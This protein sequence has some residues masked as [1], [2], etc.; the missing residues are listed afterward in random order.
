MFSLTENILTSCSILSIFENNVSFSEFQ[1]KRG[2]TLIFSYIS[3]LGPFWRIPKFGGFQNRNIFGGY[4]AF[5][6]I[7]GVTTKFDYI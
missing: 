4:E 6:D 3:R 7:F 5:V 1:S 2:G